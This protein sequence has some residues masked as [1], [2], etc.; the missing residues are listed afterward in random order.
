MQ[1]LFNPQYTNLQFQGRNDTF[2]KAYN[3]EM[4][5]IPLKDT[6]LKSISDE[7]NLLGEGLSKKGYGLAG[8]KDY[9][10]RIYKNCFR[11]EDLDREF[12]KPKND[13]LNTLE[14][15]VL[16]IPGKIDI[17][18]KKTGESLGV[19]KYAERIQVTDSHPLRD[20]KVTREETLKALN[21]YEKLKDFPVKSYKQAYLQMKKFCKK[22]G[23]QFDIISP[24]NILIDTKAKKINLI[25]PVTPKVNKPVHGD[26]ADFSKYHGCD[27]LYPVICDFIMQK[28]HLENLTAD[29]KLKWKKSINVIIAKCISA[30]KIAGFD[31]NIKQLRVLY[32]RIERFWNTN[33]LCNRYDNFID[34][35]S[36]TINQEKTITAALNYKNSEQER[37]KEI[38]RVDAANFEEIKPVF[39]KILEA[40]H[41]PKVEFPEIINAVLD[42]VFEY[43]SDAKSLV[44]ALELLF[45][46]EIFCTTKKR[47][48][49]LFIA[50]EP[51]NKKFLDEIGKSA[52]NPIEKMLFKQEFTDLYK[53]SGKHSQEIYKDAVSGATIPQELA[54]KLWIS[55]TCTNTGS[56]QEISIKN[57][58]KAYNY[59]ESVKNRKPE[60]A[61]L[62][63]LHKIVLA[64]T[65][66]QELIGGRLRTPETDELVRQIFH[67]TKDPKSVVNDY[68]AS[69]DVVEDLKKLDEYI[70][71][72]YDTMDCFTHA[73]NIFSEVI[74]IHPFLNGNGRAARLFTEEFL[75]SKGYRLDKWPEEI[76][77]RKIYSADELAEYIRR[78]SNYIALVK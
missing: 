70:N 55:R 1:I 59:I 3:R 26:N 71:K 28:E 27:S 60:V 57:M 69:K 36:G 30:G 44:P 29:E 54:D 10:I 41:Q 66:E 2:W 48:Y 61:D 77:Y 20:V 62:V 65:P 72:N 18:K 16:C 7:N 15:V 4:N 39:E 58:I 23:F 43:G 11:K 5:G 45:D 68:S 22:T 35:Y 47:L 34:M 75:L 37:I 78:S 50:L 13:Y 40:P 21:I 67:V 17:V 32:E 19:E 42:K 74:R 8:I 9:V 38:S 56:M 52:K 46:K 64:D 53:K 73:A 76:L 12:V 33:E 31:R 49:R 6:I 24:N 63:K 14:G 51:E 25:D